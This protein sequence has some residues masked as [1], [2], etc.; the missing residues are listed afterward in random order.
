MDYIVLDLEWNQ[1]LHANEA[2][3]MQF[4]II[5]IGA[6]KLNYNL[7]ETGRFNR[8]VK[9][10]V[11]KK[12]NPIIGEITGI[13]ERDFSK[14]KGFVTVIN[15]FLEWCGDDYIICTFG[16]QDIHEIEMNMIYHNCSIPWSFP[17]KYIDVQRIFGIE[18][19]DEFD[20]RSLE[21][22]SIFMGIKQQNAYHRALND[23]LY[24]AEIMRKMNKENLLK[25][26]SVDY[27][28][29]PLSKKEEVEID[30]GNHF[31]YITREFNK[32]EDL[33]N[34][35][36][37]YIT[38]CP[39]CKKKCRKKIRWF[40]DTTKYLCA[41]RCEVHGMIEGIINIKKQYNGNY[42]GVRKTSSMDEDKFMAIIKR[43]E[44]LREKRRIKRQ[45][46]K[47]NKEV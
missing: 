39:V 13:K 45:K 1:A 43:K 27:A 44:L 4:E 23:A 41:A 11:Y 40:S 12:M 35:S 25:Y 3:S 18:H 34:Y 16:S 14:E 33:L 17:L 31:Q 2:K 36:D 7:V 21:M 38:R 28:N 10:S 22:V 29:L 20:Q 15:D 26:Q 47:K 46:E 42:Y 6:V 24:T 9:P 19:N 5:E 37:L 30:C 8:L 32:K